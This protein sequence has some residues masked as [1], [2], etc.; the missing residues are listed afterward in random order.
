VG[1]FAFVRASCSGHVRQ[2]LVHLSTD[3]PWARSMALLL[4]LPGV[5]LITALT[6]TFGHRRYY[7]LSEGFVNWWATADWA[8]VSRRRGRRIGLVAKPSQGRRDLR[9]VPVESAWIAVEHHLLWKSR[10][11]ALGGRD[12]QRE[13]DYRHALKLLVVMWNVLTHQQGDRFTEVEG[14]GR[15]FMKW[16]EV[17]RTA[18][19]RGLSWAQFARNQLTVVGLGADLETLVYKGHRYTLPAVAGNSG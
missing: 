6:A 19:Y 18:T 8:A 4:Q 15:K 7:P 9:A 11:S 16:G 3:D 2:D 1:W 12:G 17:H 5:G 10:F 14:V 13:S